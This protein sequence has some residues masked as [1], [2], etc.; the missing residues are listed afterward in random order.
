MSDSHARRWPAS[1]IAHWAYL[2]RDTW[3]RLTGR[4]LD[5]LFSRYAPASIRHL[6]WLAGFSRALGD[7]QQHFWLQHLWECQDGYDHAYEL[8]R[9]RGIGRPPMALQSLRLLLTQAQEDARDLALYE[10]GRT[11]IDLRHEGLEDRDVL[12]VLLEM[13]QLRMMAGLDDAVDVLVGGEAA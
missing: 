3:D 12:D 11:T 6:A 2:L 10:V 8:K 13:A 1:I 7:R 4:I 9:G 5:D